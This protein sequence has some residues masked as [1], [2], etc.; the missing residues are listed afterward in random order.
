VNPATGATAPWITGLNSAIDI[1]YRVS[2]GANQFFVLGFSSN[3]LANPAGPGQ[4]WFYDSPIGK[5]VANQL[6]APTGLVVDP[7]SG[8]VY[9][10]EMGPGR[11]TRV[12]VP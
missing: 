6:V 11:I 12:Q 4:L 3:M 9:V 1:G 10:A 7:R 2:G 8:D 5:V